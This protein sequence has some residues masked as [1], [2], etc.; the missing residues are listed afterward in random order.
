MRTDSSTPLSAMREQVQKAVDDGIWPAAQFAVA[1]HGEILAFESFGEA[2]DGD[3]LC[4]FS[5]TKPVVASVV[6]QLLGEGRITLDTKVAEVWPEFGVHGK[7]TITLEHLLL[8]TCGLTNAAIDAASLPDR[9][10]RTAAIAQ[11]EPEWEPGSRYEYHGLSAH[12]VLA[13]LI[14]RLTGQNYREALRTRVLDPLGLDRLELGVPK[15]RQGDLRQVVSTGEYPLDALEAILGRRV[16][17][18]ILEAGD[19]AVRA[20]ANDPETIALGVPGANAFSDA[21]SVALFYQELLHNTAGLWRPD[22]LADATG[23]IRNTFPADPM[24]SDA[25]ANR[26]IGL[27]LAGDGDGEALHIPGLD[28][29]LQVRAYGG[30]TS[31]RAFGH[32]GAGG[33]STWADPETALSFCLLTSGMDRD[34]VRDH[35]RH[36]AIESLVP[37]LA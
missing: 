13:E 10:T 37:E 9:E 15:E 28:T 32:V 29:P 11:W 22:I 25:P 20:L 16:D 21:A 2:R 14:E 35:A 17:V 36:T 31:P 23:R 26:S 12:W 3:R 18:S 7:D 1:R 6:W 24:R 34:A 8:H 27:V 4:M 19:A 33:Q 30:R 5:T